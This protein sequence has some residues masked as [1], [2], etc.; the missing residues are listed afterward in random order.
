MQSKHK[1]PRK[2]QKDKRRAQKNLTIVESYV[3]W[4]NKGVIAMHTS[5]MEAIYK[6]MEK[7]ASALRRNRMQAE[8]VNTRSEARE[9]LKEYLKEGDVIAVGG[10][11]TLNEIDAFEILRDP[12]YR[13]LDRYEKDVDRSVIEERMR[14][15]FSADVFVTST[16][17]V[18]MD[19]EL[20]NVD[21]N[22]NRVAPMIFGPKSVVVIVG[23]NK[24][25]KDIDA[26]AQ[27]V[28]TIAAPS[29]A[30]RLNSDKYCAR[31]GVCNGLR[32]DLYEPGICGGCH[33]PG[34]LCC[35]YVIMS[36]QRVEGRV[37]VIL[38]GEV[39]GF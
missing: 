39:L 15:A 22:G 7:T 21:G 37:K 3:L 8:I 9:K 5:K 36:Q 24:I 27:R 20:Y 12:K 28:K 6:H 10:S 11:E 14:G 4:E 38:V 2:I 33:T 1:F 29:N 25:V 19:G 34:R 26:A 32:Q 18:T 35:D 13:F 23:Y 31:T 30:L 16:N 17:A